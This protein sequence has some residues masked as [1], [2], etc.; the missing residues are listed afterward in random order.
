MAN[1]IEMKLEVP[2]DAIS[3]IKE[4]RWRSATRGNRPR[5]EKLTSVY[6]DT[7]K[8][9]LRRHGFCLR[10]RHGN[11]KIVQTVKALESGLYPLARGEWE[12][13]ISEAIPDLKLAKATP[14]KP[15]LKK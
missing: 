4:L 6:F 8:S 9:H 15:L 13:E 1:E 5:T 14:L 7:D 3:A 2:P 10:V 11:G 12:N